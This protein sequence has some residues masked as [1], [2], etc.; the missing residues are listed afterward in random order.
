MG[1]KKLR[2]FEKIKGM[3]ASDLFLTNY[4]PKNEIIVASDTSSHGIGT[5][6]MHKLKDNSIKPIAHASRTLL[7]TKKNYSV[8]EK[9]SLEIVFILKKY[10]RF[11]NG[12]KFTLQ[13]DPRPLL[14]ISGL[15]KGLPTHTAN[16][17][18]QW[19]TILLNYDFRMEF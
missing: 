8:I 19:R 15:K 1:L 14:V 2:E 16:R 4:N 12:R 7:P 5:C 18:Q 6:I 3:L 11:L 10:H 13:M 9:E 17:L